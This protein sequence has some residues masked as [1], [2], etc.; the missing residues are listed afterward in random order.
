MDYLNEQVPDGPELLPHLEDVKAKATT[1]LTALLSPPQSTEVPLCLIHMDF[2][3]QNLLF[4]DAY[5]VHG[6]IGIQCR[7]LD[8]QNIMINTPTHDLACLL[9]TSINPIYRSFN[10][11]SLLEYYWTAFKVSSGK[12]MKIKICMFE[13]S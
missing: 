8:W 12:S 6:G 1:T 5:A 9:L 11:T 4:K 3:D 7:I 13:V 2:W 10:T